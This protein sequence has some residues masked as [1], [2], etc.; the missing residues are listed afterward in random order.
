MEKSTK[1]M[2]SDFLF[3]EHD[4]KKADVIFIPGSGQGSLA[5]HAAELY[6]EGYAPVIIP[7]GKYSITEGRFLGPAQKGLAPDELYETESDY[8]SAVLKA[9]GVPKQAIWQERQATYTYENAVFTERLLRKKGTEIKNAIISCQAYHAR[10]CLMYYRLLFPDIELIVSPVV[11]R[12]ISKDN[13]D[14]DCEKID[15]VLGE[16]ERCGSQ[17]HEIFKERIPKK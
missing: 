3:V 13:W 10:R 15:V 11:T 6:G 16:M 4:K 8:L 14:L 12:G 1:D 9:H 7:S 5:V 2:I 17:F